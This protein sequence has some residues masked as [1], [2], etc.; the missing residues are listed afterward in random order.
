MLTQIRAAKP[1][2]TNRIAEY[3]FTLH[4]F[5]DAL[6]ERKRSGVHVYVLVDL[7]WCRSHTQALEV[8]EDLEAAD[9]EVKH[10]GSQCMHF[11]LMIIGHVFA[12]GG[13]TNLSFAAFHKNADYVVDVEGRSEG[14]ASAKVLFK[15][16][17][18]CEHARLAQAHEVAEALANLAAKNAALEAEKAAGKKRKRSNIFDSQ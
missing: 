18:N 6:A 17:Y 15:E 12:S 3:A 16:E 8:I 4:V 14:V 10:L 11:K 9:I 2:D 5:S 1:G 13:S 7:T